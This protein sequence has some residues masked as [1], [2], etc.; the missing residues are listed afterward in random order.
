M[1]RAVQLI[2]WNLIQPGEQHA[3]A[4]CIQAAS[5]TARTT[6]RSAM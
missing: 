4:S 5:G 3:Y 6:N 2:S 1:Q